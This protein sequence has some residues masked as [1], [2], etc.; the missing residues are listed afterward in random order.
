MGWAVGLKD[1]GPSNP[2]PGASQPIYMHVDHGRDSTHDTGVE[3]GA[4]QGHLLGGV[5]TGSSRSAVQ[6]PCH[7][8]LTLVTWHT[9]VLNQKLL[10]EKVEHSLIT[11]QAGLQCF[12]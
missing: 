4:Q 2:V 3:P 8:A 9:P 5:V 7:G 10:H 6:T 1:W 11:P 12:K